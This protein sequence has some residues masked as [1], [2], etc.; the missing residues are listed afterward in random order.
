MARIELDCCRDG[1]QQ[2]TAAENSLRFF[3]GQNR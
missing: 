3:V 2:K 1:K